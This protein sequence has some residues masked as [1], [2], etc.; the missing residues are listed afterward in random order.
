M[1]ANS[2]FSK[3]SAHDLPYKYL[4]ISRRSSVFVFSKLLGATGTPA[5]LF[6][7][8]KTW[9]RICRRCSFWIPKKYCAPFAFIFTEDLIQMQSIVGMPPTNT[10]SWPLEL[11]LARSHYPGPRFTNVPVTWL[12]GYWSGPRI[13]A[14]G[15]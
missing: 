12:P 2:V 15:S 7:S 10:H 4:Q 11:N 5:A 3:L 14:P 13:L 6:V 1:N 9:P 8:Q